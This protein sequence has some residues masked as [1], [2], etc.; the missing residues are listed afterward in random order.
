MRIGPGHPLNL[1][2]EFKSPWNV[3][4]E[5]IEE[6]LNGI[7]KIPCSANAIRN[8]TTYRLPCWPS[9]CRT[10]LWLYGSSL[11]RLWHT[12]HPSR[13]VL[14]MPRQSKPNVHDVNVHSQSHP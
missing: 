8:S 13:L 14:R 9:C 2:A 10:A 3:T 11:S 6:G 4:P 1:A 5:S 7:L 12:H